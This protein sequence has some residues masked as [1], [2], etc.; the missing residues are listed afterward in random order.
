[1]SFVKAIYIPFSLS[2][3]RQ[4]KAGGLN[5][6]N[7]TV[8]SYSIEALFSP[9]PSIAH[10]PSDR[11]FAL[12]CVIWTWRL[13]DCEDNPGDLGPTHLS[14]QIYGIP[15]PSH[16]SGSNA[17]WSEKGESNRN[18]Y[19]TSGANLSIFQQ[20]CLQLRLVGLNIFSYF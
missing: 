9:S 6:I 7:P 5:D 16:L 19:A 13:G 10:L 20:N 11:I 3:L 1:L 18:A 17:T 14:T 8:N 12:L 2:L 15:R 4:I